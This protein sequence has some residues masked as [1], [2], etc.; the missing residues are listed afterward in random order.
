MAAATAA[1]LVRPA[2]AT[3]EQPF[4]GQTVRTAAK[5][6]AA[7]AYKAPD[8]HL[9]DSLAHLTYDQYRE[10]RFDPN[11]ALW[12]GANLPFEAQF[13]HRGFLY[14][15]RVDIYEVVGGKMQPI[16]YRPE[17]FNFGPLPRPTERDLGFAGFRLHAPILRPD[18]YD[19]VA[20]FLGASYFR[21]VGKGLGYGISSRGLALKTADQ[22]GEEFPAFRAF[23]LERPQPGTNSMVVWALLDSPSAAGAMRITLRPGEDTIMD[24]EMVL[25][26]RTDITQAGIATGTSMFM[27]DASDRA[28]HDDWRP[29]VHDSD[30][31]LMLT[32]RGEQLWRPLANP[33]TLQVSSFVDGSPRGF[34]LLQ[35]QRALSDYDDLEAHYEKRPSL[36]V[37]PI[38]DWGEGSVNLVE[39]PS[40]SE[41]NDNIVAFWRP[42]DPL[43][44]KGEYGF[45]YRLHW[46]AQP[47]ISPD[48]AR[49]GKT[50]TGATEHGRVFVLQAEMSEKLK[51]IPLDTQL[52]AKVVASKGTIKDILVT[53]DPEQ[54]AWRLSFELQ[55]GDEKL[56]ELRAT[57]MQADTPLTE[58]WLYRWTA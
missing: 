19:E 49:F 52:Q 23:Y 53:P 26:P 39:I 10:I 28:T 9:P 51:A 31:L 11:Q 8:T 42:K 13:F 47:P 43:R 25:Y 24:I 12:H 45:T 20:V 41:T 4:D 35:R 33:R 37:E 7:A 46:C 40:N 55:P 38:G 2:R 57:L 3:G 16:D 30:G 22:G 1:L 34:G 18:H 36:W 32:G 58:T 14:P 56:C 5:A 27:F 17:M 6:L 15:A 44:A 29:A 21:A 54:N 48:L 50:R